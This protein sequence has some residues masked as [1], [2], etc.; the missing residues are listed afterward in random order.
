MRYCTL[1]SSATAVLLFALAL[2]VREAAA[3]IIVYG[4]AKAAPDNKN[5]LDVVAQIMNNDFS[6]AFIAGDLIAGAHQ[7]VV[8]LAISNRPFC[9]HQHTQ[10]ALASHSC[11]A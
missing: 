4:D 7:S 8:G 9:P 11:A 10:I 2:L 1:C 6:A 5:H 3:V